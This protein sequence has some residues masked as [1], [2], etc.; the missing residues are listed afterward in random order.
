MQELFKIFF[1]Y[2]IKNQKKSINKII[3]E[4]L[5]IKYLNYLFYHYIII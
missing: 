4:K 3:I 2:Y 1:L 5:I